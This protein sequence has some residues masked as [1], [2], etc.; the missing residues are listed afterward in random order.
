MRNPKNL[1]KLSNSRKNLRDTF[2]QRKLQ[3]K[4]I[5]LAN[6]ELFQPVIE[7]QKELIQ[8]QKKNTQE[9]KKAIEDKKSKSVNIDPPKIIDENPKTQIISNNSKLP[10]TWQASENITTKERFFNDKKI[11]TNLETLTLEIEGSEK[12]FPMTVGF[13]E[14]IKGANLQDYSKEDLKLYRSFVE[15]A[16][17]SQSAHRYKDL[18]KLL[19]DQRGDG[20]NHFSSKSRSVGKAKAR[21]PKV[22]FLS[23]NPNELKER[24]NIL[25]AAKIE[26][27]D[28]NFNEINAILDELLKMK[29]ITKE[30]LQKYLP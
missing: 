14:L 13:L 17:S 10:P 30:E 6:S 22:Q 18:L 7:T 15:E 11:T 27:H 21:E 20:L 4:G 19:A 12:E 3:Q 24:L 29:E 23:S 9:I 2:F 25:L 1:L 28:N 26:G 16:K 8:E 5:D